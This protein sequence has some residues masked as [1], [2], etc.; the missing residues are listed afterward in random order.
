MT[1]ISV[2]K[3]LA[4]PPCSFIQAS[5]QALIGLGIGGLF[6]LGMAPQAQAAE[7]VVL[8][9]RWLQRSIPVADLSTLAD[10][11]EASPQLRRYLNAIGQ[12]PEEFRSTLTREVSLDPVM[13]D[14]MLNNPL[15]N[16]ALDQV[17]PVIHTR[18]GEGDRQAL[19]A[20][21]ILSAS[22]D[23]QVSLIELIENYP[24]QEIYVEGD[25]LADTYNDIE[26]LRDR[27]ERWTAL[28][29][30]PIF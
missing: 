30:T 23:E 11:G 24:T 19:R 26:A 20:A 6:V 7:Q 15:G 28:L 9:Y 22:D 12:D 13:L 1:F 18:S 21:F 17:S 14:R 10:T 8:N 29:K 27:I 3:I 25:R 2:S 16:F 4:T 5:I